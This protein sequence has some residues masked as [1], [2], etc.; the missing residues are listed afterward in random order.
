MDAAQNGQGIALVPR[1]F[2]KDQPVRIVWQAPQ[3]DDLGFYLVWPDRKNPT[4][5]RVIDWLLSA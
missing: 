2:L 5:D 3:L 1:I 4:R